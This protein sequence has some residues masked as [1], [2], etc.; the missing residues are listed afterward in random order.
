MLDGSLNVLVVDDHV[1][2]GEAVAGMISKAPDLMAEVAVDVNQA[3]AMI[4]QSGTYD[5]VLCDYPIPG[6]GSLGIGGLDAVR[7]LSEAN[8]GSV[9]LFSGASSWFVIERAIKAGARG[10]VPKSAPLKSLNNAIRFVASGEMYLPAEYMLREPYSDPQQT[11][12]K[13]RELRVLGLVCE[14]YQNTE[15]G[16]EL[17]LAETIVKLDVKSVCQKLG[18]R[19]RTQA[20]VMA[21]RAGLF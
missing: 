7:A 20:A 13:L 3:H 11:D 8:K 12:L 1:A 6:A 19:N 10:V 15:I 21:I 14:G 16:E 4:E 2:V 17:G 18:A 9:A 5:V